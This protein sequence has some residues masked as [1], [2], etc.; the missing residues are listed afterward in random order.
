VVLASSASL[1][2]D[3]PVTQ[4]TLKILLELP[5]G[6]RAE[7]A[8]ALWESLD[9][10]QRD[11]ELALTPEQAQELER[12]LSEHLADPSTAIPWKEVRRRI[13]GET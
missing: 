4:D 7:I 2:E 5:P 9:E 12:R 11:A 1:W 6:E 3:D 8:M 10:T 13:T